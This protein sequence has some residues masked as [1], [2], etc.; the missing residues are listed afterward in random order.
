MRRVLSGTGERQR[1]REH[2]EIR[3]SCSKP[4]K[5]GYVLNMML[6][7]ASRVWGSAQ[8][9]D[10]FTFAGRV[11]NLCATDGAPEVDINSSS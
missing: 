8:P 11:V 6:G 5:S 10:R 9:G 3:R 2:P 1:K 4:Y 7:V